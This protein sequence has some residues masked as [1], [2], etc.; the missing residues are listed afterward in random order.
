MCVFG[1]AQIDGLDA[2]IGRHRKCRTV[3]KPKNISRSR[4]DNNE[5]PTIYTRVF[6]CRPVRRT[7]QGYRRCRPTLKFMRTY[8][9]REPSNQVNVRAVRR[10]CRSL[11]TLAECPPRITFTWRYCPL[12]V[13]QSPSCKRHTTRPNNDNMAAWGLYKYATV[14]DKSPLAST[15]SSFQQQ[16]GQL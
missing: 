15:R 13:Q 10:T 11:F 16:F 14:A 6:W 9:T 2:D 5:N 12:D 1:V 8:S 7:Q 4:T 3:G